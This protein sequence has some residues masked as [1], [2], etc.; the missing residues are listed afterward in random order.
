LIAV[1]L[2]LPIF[3]LAMWFRAR[4]KRKA[5]KARDKL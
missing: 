4:A 1:A 2:V 3:F 5:N